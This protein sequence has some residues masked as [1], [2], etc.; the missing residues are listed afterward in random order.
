MVYTLIFTNS[1]ENRGKMKNIFTF[2]VILALAA[3]SASSLAIPTIVSGDT[4][5]TDQRTATFSG[6]S[7]CTYEDGT[8]Y[9]NVA[10]I[11]ALYP[12]DPWAYAGELTD[13]GV[14][15]FLTVTAGSWDS[16]SV[17]GTWEIGAGF[18]ALYDEAVVSIHVGQ[19]GGAPDAWAW[20]MIPGDPGGTWSY[21]KLSGGGG[22][23]SNIKLFGRGDGT[24][25]PEPSILALLGI[26]LIGLIGFAR[27]K[28]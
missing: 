18:W 17:S 22:G 14:D 11:N 27:R 20:L 8:N 23:L 5:G 21:D 13:N 10:D 16:S 25:V 6:A 4:C 9:N 2:I 3:F 12:T 24:T 15:N 7:E 1:K 28:A 26:G 19:G